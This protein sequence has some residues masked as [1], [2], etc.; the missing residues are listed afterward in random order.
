MAKRLLRPSFTSTK[1]SY[2]IQKSSSWNRNIVHS[3]YRKEVAM[4]TFHSNQTTIQL[5]TAN[6]QKSATPN[7]L[8]NKCSQSARNIESA[9]AKIIKGSVTGTLPEDAIQDEATGSTIRFLGK[10]RDMPFL[11]VRT[12]EGFF[13]QGGHGR[14]IGSVVQVPLE[15]HGEQAAASMMD[16]VDPEMPNEPSAKK[17]DTV[18]QGRSCKK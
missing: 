3:F 13:E 7:P 10:H 5:S 9:L 8:V 16:P 4:P 2:A 17:K 14:K 12:G 6:L 15:A 1:S 18:S 11:L